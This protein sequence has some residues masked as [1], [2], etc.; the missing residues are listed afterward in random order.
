[1]TNVHEYVVVLPI[2]AMTRGSIYPEEVQLPLHCTV[3][4]WFQLPLSVEGLVAGVQYA[5]RT[6]V[7]KKGI[8]LRSSSHAWFGLHGNVSVHLLAHNGALEGLHTRLMVFLIQQ[9]AQFH[10]LDWIGAGYRPHVTDV[11]GQSF[12][13]GS[14]H[15]TDRFTIIERVGR[16]RVVHDS[17]PFRIE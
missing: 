10:S 4:R 3:M 13:P 2:A 14:T 16:G 15:F 5:A 8:E 7:R 1:M 9:G 17:H 11:G 12:V 6:T